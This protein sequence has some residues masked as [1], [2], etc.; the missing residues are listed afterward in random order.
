MDTRPKDGTAS[1]DIL[2]YV[3]ENGQITFSKGNGN[4]VNLHQVI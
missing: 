2:I 1:N 3:G 4:I